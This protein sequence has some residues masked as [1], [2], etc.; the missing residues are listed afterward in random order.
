[1]FNTDLIKMKIDIKN[2][3]R[4]FKEALEVLEREMPDASV[5]CQFC[6]WNKECNF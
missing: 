2:A 4:I 5:E 1:V 6:K 3:E